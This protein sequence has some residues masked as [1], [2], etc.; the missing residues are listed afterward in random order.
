MTCGFWNH[1]STNLEQI[2]T[3]IQLASNAINRTKLKVKR[4]IVSLRKPNR[5]QTY[6]GLDSAVCNVAITELTQLE[7]TQRKHKGKPHITL[8]AFMELTLT[9]PSRSLRLS[10]GALPSY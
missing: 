8:I 9:F 10:L 5:K 1:K 6:S 7:G 4:I 2:L 3:N